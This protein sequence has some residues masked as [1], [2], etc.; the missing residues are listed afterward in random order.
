[1]GGHKQLNYKKA[2]QKVLFIESKDYV[3][4]EQFEE[5]NVPQF[6]DDDDVN[7]ENFE[8][9]SKPLVVIQRSYLLPRHLRDDWLCIN[10]FYS[11]CMIGIKV[12]EF[13][14]NLGSCENIVFEEVVNM[15]GL[16]MERHPK[17][18]KLAWLKRGAKLLCQNEA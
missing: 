13:V 9:D 5:D 17:L 2:P 8:R 15:L 18:Y 12:W 7:Q 14:I 16:M 4:K 11:T 6:D 3:E 1:M 10:I